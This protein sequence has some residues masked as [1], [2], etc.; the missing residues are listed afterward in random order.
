MLQ[1]GVR[2]EDFS[3]M[4]VRPVW[5]GSRHMLKR[6]N[7]RD[8]TLQL[9][10]STVHPVS[11]VRY[12]M[13]DSELSMKQHVTKVASSC[14]YHLRRL[15]Q[16]RRLVGKD[17]TA[18]LVSAITLSRQSCR[19]FN[20]LST[21]INILAGGRP[22]PPEILPPSDLPSPVNG[23]LWEVSELITQERIAVGYSNLVEGLT[24]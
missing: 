11:T 7:D 4:P 17:V 5:F 24:T 9:D 13:L 3:S 15:K 8:L 22:L 6:V 10:S 19:A 23:I 14:F 2:R 18:K 20:C 21:D 1:T 16:I 12:V